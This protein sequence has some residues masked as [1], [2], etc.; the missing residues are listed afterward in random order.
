[1]QDTLLNFQRFA[2]WISVCRRPRF[3]CSMWLARSLMLIL[4][5][6]CCA[7]AGAG[8]PLHPVNGALTA[9]ENAG[10]MSEQTQLIDQRPQTI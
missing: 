2:G 4:P 8:N 9:I 3:A 6:C 10:A 5:M 7:V 1:M